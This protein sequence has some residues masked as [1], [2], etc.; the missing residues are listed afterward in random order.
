MATHTHTHTH[1]PPA[2]P[3]RSSY[4]TFLLPQKV[5]LGRFPITAPT[6]SP[7]Q[8]HCS[9]FSHHRWLSWVFTHHINGITPLV[10]FCAW[11]LSLII[12][13]LKFIH[14]VAVVGSFLL[15]VVPL[16]KYTTVYSLM[17]G[18]LGFCCCKIWPLWIKLSILECVFWWTYA[19]ISLG[20]KSRGRI[21]RSEGRCPFSFS[22]YFQCGFITV[23][24]C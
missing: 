10:V 16:F 11:L 20:D 13:S 19:L 9:D 7:R 17:N 23:F 22:R 18:Y 8:N 14:V 5:S 21:A 6:P 2:W 12:I 24:S 1:T 4:R 3:P 15:S